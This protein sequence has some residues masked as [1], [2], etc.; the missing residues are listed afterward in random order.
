MKRVVFSIAAVSVFALS[1]GAFAQDQLSHD[2]LYLVAAGEKHMVMGG[3]DA[4]GT[5]LHVGA[6]GK[7]DPCPPGHFYT[8][9]PSQRMVMRCDD[10]M[11]FAL[12]APESGEMMPT[13]MPYPEGA[14]IMRSKH[15]R[16]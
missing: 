15:P 4:A 12:A 14:M 13:G 11:E 10:D 6:G 8:T 2:G 16:R 7:P 9:D 5:E 1:G 3:A